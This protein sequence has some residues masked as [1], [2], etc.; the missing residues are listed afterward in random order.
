MYVPSDPMPATDTWAELRAAH[1]RSTQPGA[2]G[3]PVH[4]PRA[5]VL[6]CADARISPARLFDAQAGELFVVRVAGATATAEA[7]ASLTY[8]IQHLDV[9]TIV[10]LGHTHCG[11]VGAAV[12][13]SDDASLGSLTSPVRAS[14][15]GTDCG[16]ATCAVPA[17]VGAT[18]A[19]LRDD[20]GPLGEAIR[21]GRVAL[22]GAV[23]DL[24]DGSIHELD[25]AR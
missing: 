22:H 24:A 19:A 21:A 10:V 9:P 3:V 25:P 1:A 17:H 23:L 16:D 6:T 13:G 5:A 15:A 20:P 4:R 14:L 7:V 2:A 8:A 18:V 11:A 12:A